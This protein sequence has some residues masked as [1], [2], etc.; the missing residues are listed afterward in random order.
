MYR[1]RILLLFCCM[2]F[3][4]LLPTSPLWAEEAEDKD[5][6]VTEI[7]SII[8]TAE[9]RKENV[10]D[11]PISMSVFDDFSLEDAGINNLTD[12]TNST[13]NLYSGDK[14]PIAIRGISSFSGSLH[15]P[16]G[17]FVDGISYPSTYMQDIDLVD[18]ER[19]E[20]LRGPQGT[21]YGRNTESGVI[22]IHTKQPGNEFRGKVSGTLELYDVD[23]ASPYYKIS[24]AISGPIVEDKFFMGLSFQGDQTDGYNKNIYNDDDSFGESSHTYVQGSAKWVPTDQ[25]NI[26]FIANACDNEDSARIQYINGPYATEPYQLNWDGSNINEKKI[27]SQIVK[28]EYENEFFDI[29]SITSRNDFDLNY[30]YD[31]DWS[32]EPYGNMKQKVDSVMVSQDLRISSP[33]NS[34]PLKWLVGLYGFKEDNDIESA[35]FNTERITDI[36]S[37]GAAI[38]GQATYT[39]AAKLH[40]TAGLRYEYQETEGTQ[41]NSD[42]PEPFSKDTDFEEIL[43]KLAASYDLKDNIMIYTSVAKGFLAG[44]VDYSTST[45]EENLAY[46]P[47]Y[48]WNYEAGIK[49]SWFDKKLIMNLAVFY[50]DM[51]DKQVMQ[52]SAGDWKIENVADATSTGVELSFEA[53][54]IQGLQIFCGLGLLD[55]TVD[56]WTKT[57]ASGVVTDYKD[58]KLTKAPDYTYNLGFKY[59]HH[60]NMFIRTELI[61]VG[62]RYYDIANKNEIDAYILTNLSL[63]YQG[64]NY[65]ITL[66]GENVFEE[67]YVTLSYG[68]AFAIYGQPRTVSLNL[69]YRF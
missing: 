18:I 10:Q 38:Y 23:D 2:C 68:D 65:D 47:E 12:L 31:V 39:V 20:V 5:K 7:E 35:Y 44:G 33:D 32:P 58:N 45:S 30:D 69:T 55:A 24:G 66:R 21:L 9:K 51:K 42:N 1:K 37:R 34:G 62:E 52:Y 36:E 46:D 22:N 26:S 13:P 60:S 59:T 43:P 8:V 67:E 6:A 19:V 28:A 56:E 48:T 64:E 27:N 29:V 50:I 4:L 17:I 40:L 41:L 57:S 54:P 3:G 63:G 14:G 25:F 49:S 61:G 15:P 16:G 11:V 53:R